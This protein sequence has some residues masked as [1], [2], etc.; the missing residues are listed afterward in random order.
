VPK[1]PA[2]KITPIHR[3]KLPA[4]DAVMVS[5]FYNI[6]ITLKNLHYTLDHSAILRLSKH[7]DI[8]SSY[9]AQY[10][11]QA[12]DKNVIPATNAGQH[13]VSANL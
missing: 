7:N 13:T 9:A 6:A 1:K 2:D 10:N 3:A 4:I 11:W 12:G 5:T 8:L